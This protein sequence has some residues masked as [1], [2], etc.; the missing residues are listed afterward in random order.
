MK[1]ASRHNQK[2]WDHT[3]YLGLGPAAHSFQEQ[4][5][6][7]ELPIL[8]SICIS[9][10]LGKVACGRDGDPDDGTTSPGG[11]LLWAP[12]KEREFDSRILQTNIKWI[13]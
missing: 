8:R 7:V 11:S 6:L 9:H 4:S 10:K 3:P 1:F 5:A 12:N 2:Y 13:S